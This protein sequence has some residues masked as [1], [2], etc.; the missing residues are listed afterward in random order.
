MLD[1]DGQ[2]FLSLR[3]SR[4][5]L[6]G[7]PAETTQ[8]EFAK[9]FCI[10]CIGEDIPE[11]LLERI[12]VPL[13]AGGPNNKS[14]PV[15]SPLLET[16]Q[17]NVYLAGDILSPAYFETTDFAR[18]PSKFVEVKRRGN[19]K[20]ALRDGVLIADV[21]AQKLA[22]KVHIDVKLEFDG[23]EPKPAEAVVVEPPKSIVAPVAA[24]VA[25]SVMMPKSVAAA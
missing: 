14:R 25:N 22:G 7:R 23:P 11:A 21:I 10:A 15:V 17:P 20:S 6:A 16:R 12:G 13:V 19:I 1:S 24:K 8:L 5:A 9:Q 3:T 2:S 18:D 4:V